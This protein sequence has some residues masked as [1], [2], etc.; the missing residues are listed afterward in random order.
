MFN[1]Q[2]RRLIMTMG[3]DGEDLLELLDVV[4][5]RGKH[6]IT[7]QLLSKI[8]KEYPKAYEY[9]RSIKAA[10]MNWTSGVAQGLVKH[11]TEGGLDA[12]RKLYHKYMPLADDLQNIFIRQL[13][14]IR[15]VNEGDM[16]SF[17][18]EIERIRELYIMAGSDEE[19]MSERWLRAAI[20]QNLPEKVVQTLAIELKRATS[21]EDMY[22]IINT[23][24][25]D[26][27]TGLPRGQTSPMLYLAEGPTP[28]NVNEI[29][30]LSENKEST[31]DSQ[32]NR[33]D[34][35]KTTQKANREEDGE[36]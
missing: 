6:K 27:R 19:P 31:K 13:M 14:S 28:E 9:D 23:Y 7:R 12:W 10:L 3:M 5:K 36:K 16:D 20:L 35:N 22:S 26:H 25:F 1:N 18:D 8:A 21:V 2:L 24:T 30:N 34:D 4:E 15:P 33:Q 32:T 17:F 11:G 29:A